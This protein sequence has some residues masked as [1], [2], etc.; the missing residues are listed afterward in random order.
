M[1]LDSTRGEVSATSFS[2]KAYYKLQQYI[3]EQSSSLDYIWLTKCLFYP[4]VE[5]WQFMPHL[6][7]QAE[8]KEHYHIPQL[9]VLFYILPSALP[10]HWE[11]QLNASFQTRMRNLFVNTV[12]Y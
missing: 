2:L 7:R 10:E 12:V 9:R 11:N 5:K 8:K 3:S 4:I 6:W 1:E